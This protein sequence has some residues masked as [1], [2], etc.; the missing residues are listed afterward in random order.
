MRGAHA[1][2][3]AIAAALLFNTVISLYYRAQLAQAHTEIAIEREQHAIH[4]K[5]LS[6]AALAAQQKA[7]NDYQAALA[8]IETLDAQLTREYQAHETD[9]LNYRL[10]LANGNERLHVA[11]ANGSTHHNRLRRM[12]K[13][14]RAPSVGDGSP[15]CA[16]L[17]PATAQSIFRVAADADHEISKL[18]ALQGYVCAVRPETVACLGESQEP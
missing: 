11:L 8:K 17:N 3:I 12:P 6:E 9:N 4:L 14:T 15:I 7:Q 2:S 1:I 16:D 18:R 5:S 13:T 10:A